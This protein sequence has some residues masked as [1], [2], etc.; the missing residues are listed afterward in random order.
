MPNAQFAVRCIDGSC[1]NDTNETYEFEIALPAWDDVHVFEDGNEFVGDR[2][3]FIRNRVI[4]LVVAFWDWEFS[5]PPASMT[6]HQYAT[7][8]RSAAGSATGQSFFNTDVFRDFV[9]EYPDVNVTQAFSGTE[10]SIQHQDLDNETVATFN[11]AGTSGNIMLTSSASGPALPLGWVAADPPVIFDVSAVETYTAM[12]VCFTYDETIVD[13]EN[14]LELF[15]YTGGSWSQ[16]SAGA[17]VANNKICGNPATL[18]PFAVLQPNT[19]PSVDNSIV[20]TPS[21]LTRGGPVLFD[22]S[23]P[24]IFSDANGDVLAFSVST[25]DSDV[26]TASLNGTELTITP[27]ETAGTATISLTADDGNLGV[28]THD[29]AVEVIDPPAHRTIAHISQSDLAN[30]VID[31]DL[32]EWIGEAPLLTNPEHFDGGI[33]AG[34]TYEEVP[35]TDHDIAVWMRW[36]KQ[37]NRIYVAARVFDDAFGTNTDP[38]NP[39]VEWKSDNMEVYL[40]ADNSGGPYSG[41]DTHAQ[42][43]VMNPNPTG[44]DQAVLFPHVLFPPPSTASAV[45]AVFSTGYTY[46]YEFAIPGW[47]ALDDQGS[48]TRHIFESQE[49]IG[50]SLAF[51]D[52]ESDADADSYSP[53]H[54]ITLFG[55]RNL[56]KNT[57]VF[58]DFI[59]DFAEIMVEE[60]STAGEDEVTLIDPE[61][62]GSAAVVTFNNAPTAAYTTTLETSNTGPAAPSGFKAGGESPVYYD[63]STTAPLSGLDTL[64]VCFAYEESAVG[65]ETNLRLY[66]YANSIWEDVTTSLD[67]I[68]NVIYGEVTSLSPF[69]FVEPDGSA[70][71]VAIPH[72]QEL[73]DTRVEV[74][75]DISYVAGHG[76]VSA[77]LFI[78]YDGDLLTLPSIETSG[79]LAES[80]GWSV[81]VNFVE[82]TGTSID[83]AK[84]ALANDTALAVDGEFFRVGFTT[85]DL[86]DPASSLL[87]FAHALV[88]DG[89]PAITALNGSLKLIG[90]D[91]SIITSVISGASSAGVIPRESVA[92]AIDDIDE[93]TTPGFEVFNARVNN[94]AQQETIAVTETASPGV[95]VGQ[96]ATE[97]SLDPSPP[98]GDG[99][100]QAKAGD[101]L[102]FCYDDRLDVSG[103]TLER[104]DQL[105]AVGGADGQLQVT[106]VSQPGDKLYVRVTDADLNTDPVLQESHIVTAQTASGELENI[107]LTELDADDDIFFGSILTNATQPPPVTPDGEVSTAKGN[108]VE[109]IYNDVLTAQGGIALLSADNTVVDPFGDADGNGNVQAFDAAKVLLHSLVAYL[110]GLE[111]LAANVDNLAPFGPVDP[112]DAS[113]ILQ[114]R[115]GL[116]AKFPVQEPTADNHPQPET[117]ANPK[118]VVVERRLAL[119]SQDNYVALWAED[120]AGILSGS[121]ELHGL[122]GR[123]VLAP[124]LEEDFLVASQQTET[125]VH[126]VFAGPV[127]VAGAG[128]LLRL[129]PESD[130]EL[131][132]IENAQ[133]NGGRMLAHYDGA[134]VSVTLPEVFALHANVPNPFNPETSIKFALPQAARVELDIYDVLGQKVRTLVS[135]DLHAGVHTSIWDGRNGSGFGV[136]SG[137]YYYRISAV[138]GDGVFTS[139]R[140]MVLLK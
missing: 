122:Q 5:G 112:F 120:R 1:D 19:P 134:L 58:T 12:Q 138:H 61:T 4:G 135:G 119:R 97:F 47:D 17:D 37:D 43:Y 133:L 11:G 56:F 51:Q 15:H 115:V 114:K 62:G 10:I 77:E 127:A 88:N 78:T 24:Q 65:D 72:L 96:I 64:G 87:D 137:V 29:I 28:T 113:L 48:G 126:A 60:T 66:H 20:V 105:V 16:I 109:F 81:E 71:V 118:Q 34:T 23:S 42:Q 136:G 38:G 92:V 80:E 40:D 93:D 85:A 106:A 30:Y 101:L 26:A 22:I 36:S 27:G 123:V 21:F 103:Q 2:T 33:G 75:I 55:V 35:E 68:N 86:R 69:L 13:D 79:T 53:D 57:N 25:T 116:I 124:G 131:A 107:T 83:T 100:V 39:G 52:I 50:L 130:G 121:I 108:T 18:S 14:T 54:F 90:T 45:S 129:Y 125:G 8:A 41:A 59:L 99:V 73:Y 3:D 89:T 94:G 9:L 117:T 82:G 67:Q 132:G 74:P 95:F 110:Q 111:L 46:F 49:V 98:S 140:K 84:V 76:I 44:T 70:P 104:C 63:L 102:V 31:G 7:L 91:G 6:K 32:S 128:E 139:F